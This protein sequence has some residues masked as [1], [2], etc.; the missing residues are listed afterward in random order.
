MNRT[1]PGTSSSPSKVN[2][3][4]VNFPT[5]SVII[6]FDIGRTFIFC[7][8]SKDGVL[9]RWKQV[10]ASQPGWEHDQFEGYKKPLGWI[11]KLSMN[12]C[13]NLDP[14]KIRKLV[15]AF[16]NSFAATLNP[17]SIQALLFSPGVGVLRMEISFA[18]SEDVARR[19][20]DLSDPKH[21]DPIRPLINDTIEAAVKSYTS[22]LD[23]E[24]EQAQAKKEES[25]ISPFTAVD[26]QKHGHPVFFV[27][28]FVN[29][30]TFKV[31]S[32]RIRDLVAVSD[33]QSRIYN[34][35]ASVGYE[36]AELF[37]DWSEALVTGDSEHLKRKI[38]N[39][40]IIAMAS[41]SAL[42]LMDRHS[43]KDLFH[44]FA[45][46]VKAAKLRLASDV[47]IKSM[48]YQ[49]VSDAVLPTRWTVNSSDL[50]LLEAIHRNWSS[51][52]IQQVIGDRMSA[53][54]L[55]YARL[56]NEQKE[57]LNTRLTMFGIIVAI[58]TLAS[59]AASVINLAHANKRFD[60][61]LS[62]AI[63]LLVG[64]VFVCIWLWSR[65]YRGTHQG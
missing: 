22:C 10:F 14:E 60:I 9:E 55:H 45:Q 18:V 29:R 26:R 65:L 61:Y 28:S 33:E 39:N 42:A 34:E 56:Q 48:A 15:T 64:L 38:E 21:R 23:G 13:A 12:K 25:R 62:L 57:R 51:E 3:N 54:S 11:A 52:R 27:L 8:P 20:E 7:D 59:A 49:D 36:G 16:Q 53:L 58:S 35:R 6:G 4:P 31:R 30:S 19:L 44:V 32:H 47:Y 37:I 40:F 50:H 41:W 17:E 43:S 46:T 2:N 5:A 1:S 24:C 63:P